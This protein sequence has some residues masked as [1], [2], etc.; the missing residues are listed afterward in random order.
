MAR[1]PY[2]GKS[3]TNFYSSLAIPCY[4]CFPSTPFSG[5]DSL[6]PVEKSFKIPSNLVSFRIKIFTDKFTVPTFGRIL[7]NLRSYNFTKN[8][9]KKVPLRPFEVICITYWFCLET[10]SIILRLVKFN[11]SLFLYITDIASNSLYILVIRN[12]SATENTAEKPF[13]FRM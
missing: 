7:E 3:P 8:T 4:S 13:N 10:G 5:F 6:T 2:W 11:W 1:W 12:I 9:W